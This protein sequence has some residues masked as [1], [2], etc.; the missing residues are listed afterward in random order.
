MVDA[1]WVTALYAPLGD[2]WAQAFPGQVLHSSEVR[3]VGEESNIP[4]LAPPVPEL[5]SLTRSDAGEVM[6]LSVRPPGLL[7]L[8]R[9]AARHLVRKPAS[10]TRCSRH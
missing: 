9:S 6:S 7:S 10:G 3:E 5:L 8:A 2:D 4:S 1:F